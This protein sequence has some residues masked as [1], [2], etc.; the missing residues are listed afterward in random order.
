MYCLDSNIVVDM[1]RGDVKTIEL[2]RKL[3]ELDI[4]TNA[5][6]LSELYEGC[7][8]SYHVENSLSAVEEYIERTYFLEF[9]IRSCKLYGQIY[10]KLQSSGK[11][12]QEQDLM[13]AAICIAH[14]ATLVTRNKKHFQNIHG[15]KVEYC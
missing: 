10:K 13:I 3:S 12:T 5:L 7:Y 8:R 2:V 6:I 1:L 14:N 9:D 11:L 15:L 4:C